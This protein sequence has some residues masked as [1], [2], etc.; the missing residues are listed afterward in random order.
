MSTPGSRM[1]R[2]Q[3]L[4]FFILSNWRY[5]R[6]NCR[7]STYHKRDEHR[8]ATRAGGATACATMDMTVGAGEQMARTTTVAH[9]DPTLL[10][11]CRPQSKGPLRI[12]SPA[13]AHTRRRG[14]VTIALDPEGILLTL[15]ADI[16]GCCKAALCLESGAEHCTIH[17][18][19]RACGQH[20]VR[21]CRN[22]LLVVRQFSSVPWRVARLFV[23]LVKP[24]NLLLVEEKRDRHMSRQ[25]DDNKQGCKTSSRE[26][27]N[28]S[29]F[30]SER[31]WLAEEIKAMPGAR[32]CFDGELTMMGLLAGCRCPTWLN[33][34]G[35]LGALEI[36]GYG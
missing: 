13:R 18:F 16:L 8:K 21:V 6:L 35:R 29:T 24:L 1:R 34:P 31:G 20:H 11:P 19:L 32:K 15:R 9:Y 10:L 4:D 3:V 26:R 30:F 12:S 36:R 14:C 5:T 22:C 7:V 23:H 17:L 27:V 28:A 33:A 25:A 2:N